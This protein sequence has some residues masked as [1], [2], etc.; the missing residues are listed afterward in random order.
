MAC[1]AGS[2]VHTYFASAADR[3]V[4]TSK[5]NPLSALVFVIAEYESIEFTKRRRT[6]HQKERG[7]RVDAVA[8]CLEREIP[9]LTRSPSARLK[10]LLWPGGARRRLIIVSFSYGCPS[11]RSSPLRSTVPRLRKVLV[12]WMALPLGM[13]GQ[14]CRN[15]HCECRPASDLVQELRQH[16]LVDGQ[17]PTRGRYQGARV[18][19]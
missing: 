5:K 19:L 4:R 1:A 12:D 3:S 15:G 13:T 7:D 18:R 9:Y 17:G 10:G 14:G 8:R 6:E 2:M 11:A 16:R